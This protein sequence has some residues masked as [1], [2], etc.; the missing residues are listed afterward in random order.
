[1]ATNRR[2]EEQ[3]VS[4]DQDNSDVI[5]SEEELDI[6]Y[7]QREAGRAVF[8]KR[9]DHTEVDE[10]VPRDVEHAE[11]ERTSPMEDDDG[12]IVTL[13]DGTVSIPVF[14]EQLV[15]EKR[16]VVRERVLVRKH[17]VTE[18]QRVVAD[19]RRERVEVEIDEDVADRLDI[20]D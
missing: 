19:L 8:R 12:E 4:D 17:T 1:M 13:P 20:D 7:R 11:T 2:G 3:I 9:V 16:L 6:R 18:Q 15:V 10:V 5:R 14:E